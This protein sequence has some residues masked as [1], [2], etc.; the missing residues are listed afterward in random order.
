MARWCLVAGESIDET[1][2]PSWTVFVDDNFHYMDEEER[3]KLGTYASYQDALAASRLCVDIFLE[4]RDEP[5]A[6]SLFDAY[7]SYGEDPFIMGQACKLG[8]SAWQYAEQRCSELRPVGTQFLW[9]FTRKQRKKA[10]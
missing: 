9:D 6:A 7:Q 10:P 3:Y 4:T 2:E 1:V 5:D 8:F